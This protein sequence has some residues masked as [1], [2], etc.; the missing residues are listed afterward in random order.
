M[1]KRGGWEPVIGDPLSVISGQIGVSDQPA[2]MASSLPISQ[3]GCSLDESG[4]DA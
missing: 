1:Q 2:G 3:T 4:K